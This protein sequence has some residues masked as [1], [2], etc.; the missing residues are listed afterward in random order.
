MNKSK[1]SITFAIDALSDIGEPAAEQ[2]AKPYGVSRWGIQ[3][4]VW[5][6]EL[7]PL[8]VTSCGSR[9]AAVSEMEQRIDLLVNN[10]VFAQDCARRR[11][12]SCSPAA[13]T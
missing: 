10:A 8:R 13:S 7:L 2:L 3:A 11:W 1:G 12:R 6:F 9:Q 5:R 4:G